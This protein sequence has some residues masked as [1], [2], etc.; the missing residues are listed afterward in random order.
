[1]STPEEGNSISTKDDSNAGNISLA[2]DKTNA[3]W[4]VIYAKA[5]W[6]IF[7]VWAMDNGKCSC[8]GKPGCSPGKHPRTRNGLKDATSDITQVKAW[9]EPWPEANIGYRPAEDEIV[10][11]VEKAGLDN[12][13]I[14]ELEKK[15]GPLPKGKASNTGGGG[16][17]LFFRLPINAPE[18]KNTA[19]PFEGLDIRTHRGY[20]I[21]PPSNH[22]S[23]NSYSWV[24]GTGF[25]IPELPIEWARAIAQAQEVTKS[26]PTK[27][28]TK[29]I[30]KGQRN[31]KLFKMCSAARDKGKGNDLILK[32][33]RQY[34]ETL[35]SEPL[36]DEEVIK[37]VDS[38]ARYKPDNGTQEEKDDYV[39]VEE[40]DKG[41]AERLYPHWI[42]EFRF[43]MHTGKWMHWNGQYWEQVTDQYAAKIAS[44]MLEDEFRAEL[45]ACGRGEMKKWLKEM[46]TVRNY[47]RIINALQFVKGMPEI[48][49]KP[50]EWDSNGYELNVLNGII[51]LKTQTLRERTSKDLVT[52]LAPVMYDQ[53]AVGERWQAHIERVLPKDEI[54]RHVQ[55][56]QGMGLV[57]KVLAEKLP[58][59]YGEGANGKTTTARIIQE[60]LG[61]YTKQAATG[62]L[63]ESRHERHP[64]ER[65]EL[66]G[67]RRVFCSEV[68]ANRKMAEGMV[69]AQ[70]GGDKKNARFMRMDGFEFEQS[71]DITLLVN[72][73]PVIEG[74]DRG[75]WRRISL[76][77]WETTIP[78]EEQEPQDEIV[79]RIV[80]EGSAVLN[81]MLAGLKDWQDNHHWG[82]ADVKAATDDYR[83]EQDMLGPFIAEK[84]EMG[85]AYF[86]SLDALYREYKK[87]GEDNEE[88]TIG[89]RQFSAALAASEV[90]RKTDSH[91][92]KT[93]FSG[94]RLK[95]QKELGD[96]Q[97]IEE[98]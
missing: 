96:E 32:E 48:A 86:D 16:K 79:E 6:K 12:G 72:H 14:Q 80:T 41:H 95:G 7:P 45:G 64:T 43:A 53:A 51:D 21:L 83:E 34:N 98:G 20:V 33:A 61:P 31:A 91:S 19:R 81:W 38:S 30:P 89:K 23:G 15:Y 82:A 3:H 73:K 90:K 60:V 11:D 54:R 25:D 28:T 52:M 37:I 93:W 35:F 77:P 65:A 97:R 57:G 44:D 36:D 85:K 92:K 1:M 42:N 2:T 49:T 67:K 58:I 66:A 62:L 94:I 10:I 29:K 47:G 71:Y 4:A 8:G 50:E 26:K 75:I 70:T 84:C 40:E 5:G 9:W 87:W 74:R 68:D 69:K 63:L 55:R 56:D 39:D 17:H 46:K 24:E 22:H 78:E 76:I 88:P 13:I 59:W 27:R 18:I